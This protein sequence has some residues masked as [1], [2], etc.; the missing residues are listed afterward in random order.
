LSLVARPGD[1]LLFCQQT[2][3]G[4]ADR[5]ICLCEALGTM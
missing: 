1:N 3:P 4:R 2:L 5:A